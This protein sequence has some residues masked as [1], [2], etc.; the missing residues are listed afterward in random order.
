MEAVDPDTRHLLTGMVRNQLI[1]SRA[2]ASALKQCR[3]LR[4]DSLHVVPSSAL[5]TGPFK[6]GVKCAYA[7]PKLFCSHFRR[8]GCVTCGR[9]ENSFIA[10]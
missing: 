2:V 9:A 10:Q 5:R 1:G 8:K 6:I 3:F 7:G 4:F